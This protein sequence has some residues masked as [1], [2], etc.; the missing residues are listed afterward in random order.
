M[1]GNFDDLRIFGGGFSK[2]NYGVEEAGKC[3][4][5]KIGRF[6]EGSK[7]CILL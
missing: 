4:G 7:L 6:C 1:V 5:A 3:T 2:S